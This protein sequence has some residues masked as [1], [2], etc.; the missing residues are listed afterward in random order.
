M[1]LLKRFFVKTFPKATKV[2]TQPAH[3]LSS[4]ADASP[5]YQTISCE[6]VQIPLWK[7]ICRE[8][9]FKI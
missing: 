9:F 3:S 6:T 5:Y 4:W 8:K 2:R 1:T 7:W